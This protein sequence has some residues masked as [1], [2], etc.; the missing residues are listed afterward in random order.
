MFKLDIDQQEKLNKWI[1]DRIKY[2]GPCGGQFT[3][4]FTPTTI[5][6]VIRVTDCVSKETIDLSDYKTW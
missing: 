6:T 5:G 3:Y 2:V 4:S 1:K